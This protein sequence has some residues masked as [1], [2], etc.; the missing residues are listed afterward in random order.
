MMNTIKVVVAVCLTELVS[1]VAM[2]D[3]VFS[4]AAT[5]HRGFVGDPANN[6]TSGSK[7]QF[8]DALRLGDAANSY[9]AATRQGTVQLRRETVD[10]PY[11]NVSREETVAYFPQTMNANNA[12]QSGMLSMNAP[13]AF[14]NANEYTAFVRFRWDGEYVEDGGGG[15]YFIGLGYS[16]NKTGVSVG[17]GR[18]G[19]WRYGCGNDTSYGTADSE[20]KSLPAVQSNVWTDCAIVVSN[21]WMTLY[22]FQTNLTGIASKRMTKTYSSWW[23]INSANNAN[24]T[25]YSKT[26]RIGAAQTANSPQTGNMYKRAFRGSI[27]SVACWPR[28]LTAAEVRQVFAWPKTDLVRLG[29]ANGSSLEFGGGASSA[30]D[31]DATTDWADTPATLTA[32]NPSLTISFNVSAQN[33]GLGQLLRVRGAN[34]SCGQLGVALNGVDLG[35]FKVKSGKAGITGL[36][37]ELIAA[38]QNT[39]V[40]SRTNSDFTFDA[41]AIGGGLQVGRR[42]GGRTEFSNQNASYQSWYATEPNWKHVQGVVIIPKSSGYSHTDMHV[43]V[44]DEIAGDERVSLSV[45][46][47]VRFSREGS[48]GNGMDQPFSIFANDAEAASLT[49]PSNKNGVWYDFSATISGANLL[50]GDNIFKFQNM[51]VQGT[52]YQG[53]AEF[54]YFRLNPHFRERKLPLIF[55]IQ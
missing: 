24:G 21:Y 12:L 39:L 38:G 32:S 53:W 16:Y 55:I 37:G 20:F 27:Q 4:N 3:D 33:A 49:I 30:T 41:I 40:L 10:Y 54:D 34:G 19:T 22:M 43:F 1:L 18:N 5:W 44:P 51:N 26:F 35:T 25:G 47:R 9:H 13:F 2:A 50:P 46:T 14:T 23:G 29:T 11:A 31:A 17:L 8:P 15:N 6:F 28:A 7:T 45:E 48:A 36:S 52:S 42:D